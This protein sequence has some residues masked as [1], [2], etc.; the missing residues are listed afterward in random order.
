M[1]GVARAQHNGHQA[2]QAE[3]GA[4]LAAADHADAHREYGDQIEDIENGLNDCSHT[5]VSFV[6]FR[7]QV[8]FLI[9]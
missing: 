6:C 4:S 8:L 7:S 3:L 5:F 2:E 9:L 1:E